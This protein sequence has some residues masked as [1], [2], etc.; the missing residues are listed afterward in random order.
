MKKTE[1]TFS[2]TNIINTIFEGAHF[3]PSSPLDPVFPTINTD[4]FYIDTYLLLIQIYYLK[5]T[6]NG[7][8]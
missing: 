8:D 5:F 2:P 4:R 3:A 7:L 6:D 1:I